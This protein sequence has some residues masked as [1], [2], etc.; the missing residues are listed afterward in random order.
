MT[1]LRVTST[2]DRSPLVVHRAGLTLHELSALAGAASRC[3]LVSAGPHG[4]A[5]V[6][7]QRVVDL[8]V[9][10]GW[11]PA[12]DAESDRAVASAWAAA[13]ARFAGEPWAPPGD[14]L[15]RAQGCTPYAYQE[16]GSA[17][18]ATSPGG[19][20]LADAPGLGK[21]LQVLLALP[22]WAA[23]NVACPRNAVPTWEDEVARWRPDLT[24]RA[25]KKRGSARPAA[26]GEVV[27]GTLES[28]PVFDYAWTS[29]LAPGAYLVCDEAHSLKGE[30]AQ[31]ERFKSWARVMQATRGSVWLLSGTPVLN[32]DPE[33]L[34]RLLDACGRAHDTL[35][36]VSGL[37]GLFGHTVETVWVP[38]RK[39]GTGHRVRAVVDGPIDLCSVTPETIAAT[40]AVTH[41]EIER[42][43]WTG[44]H[45]SWVDDALS[46]A[47]VRR[48][49]EAVFKDMPAITRQDVR[50]HVPPSVLRELSKADVG[51][52]LAAELD[53]LERAVG[54]GA[55]EEE[56]D[57]L[58]AQPAVAT[59]RKLLA[60][61]KVPAVLLALDDLEAAGEPALVFSA[62][63]APAL[64]IG[65]RPGWAIITGDVTGERRGKIRTD[66]QIGRWSTQHN[67]GTVTGGEARG[68]SM[69]IRAASESLTLTR[70]ATVLF[71]DLDWVPA[72]NEQAEA[73][74]HRIGQ[75][76]PVSVLRFVAD[77]AIDR[78]VMLIIGAKSRFGNQLLAGI[79]NR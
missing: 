66:F 1:T 25:L 15:V 32:A 67:G 59:A 34:W 28:Y 9:D 24:V 41:E 72:R 50:V 77:H 42:V 71:V 44:E 46:K 74:A 26:P 12:F 6:H 68:V 75:K 16:T 33:E 39:R 73:R 14:A 27:V 78:R 30:S 35:G 4:F 38:R 13:D 3:G 22:P 58:A 40:Q 79:E 64:E 62:H 45:L 76:R 55:R 49:K 54:A 70:A 63:V 48:T 10:L 11:D 56:L 65:E 7:P 52:R 60:A 51:R 23:V 61:A 5:A 69:S 36:P 29:Q 21:T 18:L 43:T 17:R 20:I 47:I 19:L 2:D 8:F 53:A 57:R 37:R 31:A